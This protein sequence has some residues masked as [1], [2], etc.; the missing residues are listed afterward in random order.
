MP[1][2]EVR[3][4]TDAVTPR[5]RTGPRH[6]A[7]RKPLL[8]RVPVG[9][10][11]A[12]AAM[13]TAVL[14]GMGLTP[15]L[16]QAKPGVPKNPFRDGPCVTVPDEQPGDD[17]KDTARK[18]SR[19]GAGRDAGRGGKRAEHPRDKGGTKTPDKVPETRR[20]DT[21]AP[22]TEA[23]ET[24]TPDDEAPESKAPHRKAPDP[25]PSEPANPLDPLGV[26]KA[27]KDLLTPREREEK[28]P[29]TTSPAPEPSGRADTRDETR[30]P[31]R[32]P[33]QR[34]QD[35]E[36]AKDA[37]D[38]KDTKDTKDTKA[39]KTPK[40]PAEPKESEDRKQPRQREDSEQPEDPTAPDEDGKKPFPCVV[41]KKVEGDD[42][43]TPVP[44]PDQP[45]HLEAS[46]LLLKGADYQGVV[47]LTMPDGRTKQALKYVVNAG[48]EIGDLHQSVAG[49]AGKTYHV[50]A[51]KG[52]TSTI[53]DGATTMY[54]ERISGN[55]FGLIPV[56]FDPE[57]PPPL[58]IP[59]IYFT[60]VKVQQAGQFGGTLTIPGLHQSITD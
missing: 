28:E 60:H 31:G 42:E 50:Q 4:G 33:Q 39:S 18:P 30:K 43:R 56:T 19:D 17:D 41:E 36:D 25:E 1:A 21:E 7:P 35:P 54:T 29:R 40:A 20:P 2:D 15:Q 55:L 51:A 9:K 14:M 6:A 23:P 45:W 27:L 48:T 24:K 34:S 5:G 59:L 11:I 46:S 22:P 38:A 49:P 53:T 10:A 52:S 44:I 26:G 32:Q 47:N 13:P 8:T 37:K 3:R 57:H 16:A 58:N 12:L